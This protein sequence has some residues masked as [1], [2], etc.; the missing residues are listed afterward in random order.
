MKV[1]RKTVTLINAFILYYTIDFALM[2]FLSKIAVILPD[3][4]FYTLSFLIFV[5]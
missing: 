1:I 5:I 2:I 3:A 4:D